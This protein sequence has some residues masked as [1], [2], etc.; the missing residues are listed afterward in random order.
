MVKAFHDKKPLVT[1]RQSPNLRSMLVKA[2]FSLN[3]NPVLPKLIGLYPCGKCKFCSTGYIKHTTEFT[4]RHRKKTITWNY[5]RYFS[6]DSINVLYVLLCNHCP[7]NYLGKT[8]IVK[9]R[10]SKHAS[11]VRIPTNSNCRKCAEH[12]RECSGLREPYFSYYPFFYVDDPALRHFME[13]RFILKWK[14][15]LNS[16]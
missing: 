11:D 13:K 9:P 8:Q 4:L 16:Y 12:I 6:C 15:T 1:S 14:P 10:I 7:D 2:K 3:P 5:T